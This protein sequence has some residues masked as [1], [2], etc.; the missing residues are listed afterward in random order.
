M[1]FLFLRLAGAAP[2]IALSLRPSAQPCQRFVLPMR[3]KE[4]RVKKNGQSEMQTGR[5]KSS[6]VNQFAPTAA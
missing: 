4:A 1:V 3:L 5:E 2:L 6:N